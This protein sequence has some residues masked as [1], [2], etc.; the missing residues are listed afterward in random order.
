MGKSEPNTLVALRA[1]HERDGLTRPEQARRDALEAYYE[2][3]LGVFDHLLRDGMR[4]RL[5]VS[6]D[7]GPFD[8]EFGRMHYGMELAVQAGMSPLQA[9]EAVTRIAAEACGVSA[10]TGVL[11]VGKE[12]ALLV[13]N[14][15]PLQDIQRIAHVAAVYKGGLRV[16]P[17]PE[18][19]LLPGVLG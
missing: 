17:L 6:S 14:G 9:I 12:A 1:K 16:G 13:V 19:S 10:I 4:P 5:V 11:E 15:D 3:K 8:C 2:A 7:T 18:P